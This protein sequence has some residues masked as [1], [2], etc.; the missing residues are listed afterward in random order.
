MALGSLLTLL[1]DIA[2]LLDDIAASSKVAAQKTVG[3]LGDDLAVNAEQVSGVKADREL[4]VVFAVAKGA[5]LNKCFIV[6]V[7][8][9]LSAFLP[10][11]ITPMLMLGGFYLCFEGGEKVWEVITRRGK[12]EKRKRAKP[13][14]E[15]EAKAYEKRKVK[16]AIR[17]DAILSLEVIVIALS[18]VQ[19][20]PLTVQAVAVAIVAV[21]VTFFVYGFV[22]VIVKIDDVGLYCLKRGGA[23]KGVGRALLWLAPALMK[24]LTVVGTLAMFLVG[25]GILLHGLE[26]Y[27]PTYA[28]MITVEGHSIWLSAVGLGINTLIGVVVSIIVTALVLGGEKIWHQLSHKD[29]QA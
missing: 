27:A 26:H 25:G 29:A 5:L 19:A 3:V 23:L 20:E 4:P 9:L 15:A 7:I 11:L 10:W 1:D 2:T 13:M 16:G 24:L 22:A 14:T 18:T 8:L 6:P 12:P 28:E 17:T 21:F